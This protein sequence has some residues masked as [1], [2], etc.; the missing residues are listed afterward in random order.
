LNFDTYSQCP[1]CTSKNI[2]LY[3]NGTFD[4]QTINRDLI[5]ITDS[6][7]GKTGD[8]WKCLDC[9]HIFANPYPRQE[10]IHS[11]YSASE[12]PLYEEE[13]QGRGKNFISILTTLEKYHPEKGKL[14]DV[15]A[16]TGILLDQAKHLGWIPS[17]IEASQWCVRVAKEKHNIHLMEGDFI[18]AEI[19]KSL[20]TAVTMVDFIE[21]IPQ[22]F[23]AVS[24]AFKILSP[25]GTLCLVTPDIESF[26]A[27]F[28][29]KRWWHFR[30]AHLAYFSMGSISSMLGRAGFKIV[31]VK[32]YAWTFSAHYLLSRLRPFKFLIKNAVLGSFWKKIPIKLALR[33][34]YEIYARKEN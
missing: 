18:A 10:F 5:K 14:F 29:G 26:A 22:P 8:L 27:R 7:Y 24:K 19:K 32:K 31:K 11:L 23:E 1:V 6:D 9:G 30:P 17:G 4:F 12:D 16:A 34:S 2:H 28:I 15:G 20:F 3:K 25:G 13:A 21:H 33:D